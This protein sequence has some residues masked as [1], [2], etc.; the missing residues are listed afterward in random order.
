MGVVDEAVEDGVGVGGIADGGVPAV[1]RKLAGQNDGTA[2]VPVVDLDGGRL[3]LDPP[4]GLID[5]PAPRRRAKAKQRAT[6][7]EPSP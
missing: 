3:V 5:A 7:P 6:E 1:H 2:I 4:P